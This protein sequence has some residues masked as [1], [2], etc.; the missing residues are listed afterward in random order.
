MNSLY[1]RRVPKYKIGNQ[2]KKIV[3]SAIAS[4]V[5]I[6][7]NAQAEEKYSHFPSLASADTA[8]ALCNLEAFNKKLQAIVAKDKLTPEDMV[9]VHELTYTLENAVIRLQ[10][11]LETIAVDLEEVHLASERLD[12]DTI[13]GSGKD[14]LEATSAILNKAT[15]K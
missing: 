4:L 6:A 13:K 9:K 1:Q 3:T 14:Y 7:A 8:T 15:C 12:K 11:D 10:K 2:M 5:L